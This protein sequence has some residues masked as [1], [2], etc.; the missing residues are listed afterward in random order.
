[1]VTGAFIKVTASSRKLELLHTPLLPSCRLRQSAHRF[2]LFLVFRAT[3][4][5]LVVCVSPLTTFSCS[6]FAGPPSP[7]LSSASVHSP[8]PAV[9]GFL[10]HLPPSCRLRQS[11][12]RFQLFLV[13]WATFPLL[14]VCV[15]PLTASSCSWFSGPPP[16]LLSSA[17]V[18]SPLPAVPGFLG[19]LPPS[20][21]LLTVLGPSLSSAALSPES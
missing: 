9:P 11:T 5:P 21:R 3:S 6:W 8:L 12:H 16:P 18:H 1:M 7:F 2:Q 4:P 10:G 20:C 17:S 19:H 15:S 13:F 14:V